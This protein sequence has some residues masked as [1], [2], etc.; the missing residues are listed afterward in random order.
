MKRILDL[1]LLPHAVVPL[2]WNISREDTLY[3][4]RAQTKTWVFVSINCSNIIKKDKGRTADDSTHWVLENPM[5][6]LSL[7]DHA[8]TP[9]GSFQLALKYQICKNYI[10][11]DIASTYCRDTKL[12]EPS[13]CTRAPDSNYWRPGVS[14]VSEKCTWYS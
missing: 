1:A 6:N 10:E 14:S 2:G 12:L 3:T 13:E 7:R 11:S 9:F 4:S 8:H 5:P